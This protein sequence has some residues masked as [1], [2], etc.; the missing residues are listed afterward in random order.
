M[1][2]ETINIEGFE[3]VMTHHDSEPEFL[4][5]AKSKGTPLIG[6][7]SFMKHSAHGF[8]GDYHLHVYDG[9]REIF[10]I[11]KNGT[12]HDGYHGVRI[13]NKVFHTLK[14]RFGDWNFPANQI[15]EGMHYVY[16]LQPTSLLSYRELL[17]EFDIIQ[18]EIQ[19]YSNLKSLLKEEDR[20]KF[21]TT[22]L[23]QRSEE[24]FMAIYNKIS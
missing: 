1:K 7:Y 4:T 5:E 12:A 8:K 9:K 21:E 20:D 19:L 3:M 13:P 14:T 16:I 2:E 23:N 18:R 15:I 11:N 6:N 10:A 22:P 17:N 24:L